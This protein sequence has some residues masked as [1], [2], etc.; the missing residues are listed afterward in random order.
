M[1]GGLIGYVL[2]G[3][4]VLALG[5]EMQDLLV[6]GAIG[7]FSGHVAAVWLLAR[8]RGGAASLGFQVEPWDGVY[9]FVGVGLQVVL[10]LLMAPVAAL[11]GESQTGQEVAEQIRLLGGTAA[12]IAMAFVVTIL[13]P[14]AEELMFRGILLKSLSGRGLRTASLVSA[15]C[16]G[17]FHLFGLT[18]DLLTG[19]ILLFPIFL[20]VGLVLARA[21]I[22]RGRLGPAIFIHSGFNLLAVVVLLIPPELLEQVPG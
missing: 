11:V 3:L 10:P 17:G 13:A 15:A 20:V 7:Q 16:F 14:I 9:L 2:V 12:R 6:V 8:S 19:I 22:R 21:T 4:P 5:G 18:G 1:A